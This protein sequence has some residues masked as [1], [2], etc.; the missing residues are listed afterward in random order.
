MTTRSKR[1]TLTFNHPFSL[2]GV[3]RP[4]A[5]GNYE[6]VTDEEL[7]EG[8]SHSAYRRVATLIFLPADARQPSYT[9]MV[10][11]DPVELAAA[12]ER[13]EARDEARAEAPR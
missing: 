3:D 9:E 8:V 4:L 5:A 12:Q 13:D 7:I 6:V 2:K 10:N 11:V 1:V